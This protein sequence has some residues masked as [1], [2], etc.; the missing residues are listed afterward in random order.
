MLNVINSAH[1]YYVDF[2]NE[3]TIDYPKLKSFKR[4]EIDLE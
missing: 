3:L 4:S 1:N 2:F